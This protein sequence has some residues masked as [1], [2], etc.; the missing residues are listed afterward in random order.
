MALK[1]SHP[2][3]LAKIEEAKKN[4]KEAKGVWTPQELAEEYQKLGG[5]VEEIE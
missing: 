2:R 4:L 5:K 3:D 1:M